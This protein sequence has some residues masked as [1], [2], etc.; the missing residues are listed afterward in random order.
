METLQPTGRTSVTD[1][2]HIELEGVVYPVLYNGFETPEPGYG[3]TVETYT[4][5]GDGT[6][7]AA[8][9]TIEANRNTPPQRVLREG[10]II[11]HP[12]KGN[13]FLLI[14]WP[15]GQ[16]EQIAYDDTNPEQFNSQVKYARGAY[17]SWFAGDRGLQFV[18]VC[19]PP[20]QQ[21]DLENLD[22]VNDE[23]IPASFRE[24][25]LRLVDRRS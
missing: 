7:D 22:V 24:T 14:L 8:K 11:D 20:F 15:G 3:Y 9:A 13:G 10:A 17:Q 23:S 2:Q 5:E 21:G 25:Y 6:K 16:L 1:N 19:E 18:E 12:M 4:F